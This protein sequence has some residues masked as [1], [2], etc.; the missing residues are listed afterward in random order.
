MRSLSWKI[1]LK[2]SPEKIYQSIASDSGRETFWAERSIEKDGVIE[3]HFPNGERCHAPVL[4]KTPP[5]RFALRY[6][7][8]PTTFEIV[9][10]GA[11]AVLTLAVSG[12]REDEWLD[13]YA[14]WVSVLMN[15]K[16]VADFG[17]DLRNHDAE[18]TWNQGFVDN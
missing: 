16:S 4:E 11:G 8:A 5:T 2:T 3:F 1:A 6:F 7:G 12:I 17:A 18:R 14:G 13:T 9:P 10:D 15:L